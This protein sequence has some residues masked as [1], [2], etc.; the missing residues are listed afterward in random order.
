MNVHATARSVAQLFAAVLAGGHHGD[1]RLLEPDV[2][3]RMGTVQVDGYD[4]VLNRPV[5]RGLG[6]LVEPDDGWGVA[7][8]GG[9]LL[10][11]DPS[12]GRVFVYLTR[13]LGD[14]TAAAA[15]LHVVRSCG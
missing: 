12:A 4:L 2:A 15:T 7:A 5:R 11:V 14:H 13:L 6:V 3:A 10:A 9:N 1:R 8:F